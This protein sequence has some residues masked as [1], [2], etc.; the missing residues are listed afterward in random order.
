MFP[1]LP[2]ED[3]TYMIRSI[4][5]PVYS[6]SKWPTQLGIITGVVSETEKRLVHKNAIRPEMID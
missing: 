3:E 6:K 2:S 1:L 5:V 4:Y